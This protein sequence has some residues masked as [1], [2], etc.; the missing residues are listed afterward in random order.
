MANPTRIFPSH[1]SLPGYHME[2]PGKLSNNP[3]LSGQWTHRDRKNLK[4]ALI[5]GEEIRAKVKVGIIDEDTI[6]YLGGRQRS[7][8]TLTKRS[9]PVTKVK[10]KCLEEKADDKA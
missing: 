6:R 8:L 9:K 2:E 7:Y 5:K 1:K 3:D 10:L 4:R